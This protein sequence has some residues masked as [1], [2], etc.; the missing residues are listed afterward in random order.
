MPNQ[1]HKIRT[2]RMSDDEYKTLKLIMK[3][4][5]C[6]TLKEFATKIVTQ[7]LIVSKNFSK[8]T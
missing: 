1:G 4:H 8:N 5:N 2:F 7:E 3:T 6:K